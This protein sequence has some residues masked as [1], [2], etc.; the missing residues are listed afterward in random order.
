MKISYTDAL[1]ILLSKDKVITIPNNV[2][3]KEWLDRVNGWVDD[4]DLIDGEEF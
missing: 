2:T 4:D 3:E 1:A